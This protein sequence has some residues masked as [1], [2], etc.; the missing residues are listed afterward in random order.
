MTSIKFL[1]TIFT[2]ETHI[3]IT[4]INKIIKF[5]CQL[6]H[7]E[8]YREYTYRY[9]HTDRYRCKGLMDGEVK[10]TL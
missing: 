8:H 1:L 10:L 4:K 3:K 2:L 6:L 7:G 5:P 9:I